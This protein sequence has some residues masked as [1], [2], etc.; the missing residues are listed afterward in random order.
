MTTTCLSTKARRLSL[1][2]ATA[3]G[4]ALA[5]PAS[6]QQYDRYDDPSYRNSSDEQ[7]EVTVPRYHPRSSTTGAPIRDVALSREVR[8]DDLNLRTAW[9]AHQLKVRIRSA[10][11]DL[12]QKLNI[13][14]PVSADN[15]PPCF[16]TAVHR[17]MYQADRAIGDARHEAYER[18]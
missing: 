5:T 7:I 15:S 8:F 10:A 14:Y 2:A 11:T 6:A 18:Y 12:C 3:I 1:L 9:G 17:A 4:L 13:R 16:Q